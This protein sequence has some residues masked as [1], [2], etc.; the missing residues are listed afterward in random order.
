MTKFKNSK[1]RKLR[2]ELKALK[3]DRDDLVRIADDKNKEIS[4][5]TSQNT[6]LVQS[7]ENLVKEA[8][9][10]L[11][12]NEKHHFEEKPEPKEWIPQVGDICEVVGNRDHRQ[13]G[14]HSFETGT[15]GGIT[16]IVNSYSSEYVELLDKCW[17][18]KQDLKFISRPDKPETR[19]PIF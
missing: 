7:V 1:K 8:N 10:V 4:R 15:I 9:L 18:H 11:A 14:T 16:D 17:V 6:V 3:I 5:L 2:A 13:I 19:T 12:A